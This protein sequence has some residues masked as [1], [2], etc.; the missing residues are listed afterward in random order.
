MPVEGSK[1]RYSR[2]C[3]AGLIIAR[4]LQEGHKGQKSMRQYIKCNIMIMLIV[5]KGEKNLF[6]LK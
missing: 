4:E 1:G 2:H 6:L 3:K 5:I